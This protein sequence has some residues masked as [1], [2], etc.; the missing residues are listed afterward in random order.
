[1]NAQQAPQAPNENSKRR[2]ILT[3]I[4]VG[5]VFVA[6]TGGLIWAIN[7]IGAEQI[8][9]TIADAGIFG[10]VVYMAITALTFVFAPLTSGPI[11]VGAGILFE[12]FWGVVYTVLG[13]T[14]GGSI[15]FLIARRY[16]RSVVRQLV[17]DDGLTRVETFVAQI[18]DWRTL[19]YAR[20]ILFA[21]FDFISYAAGFSRVRFRTYVIISLTAGAIPAS[22]AVLMGS[23]WT[24]EGNLLLIYGGLLVA[25]VIP[26]LL[27][28]PIRRWLKLDQPQRDDPAL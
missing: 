25:C 23:M 20:I 21:L 22:I 13:E 17:G 18:V 27:N 19:L 24:E 28:K 5:V 10:P 3:L 15:S 4:G 11:Q 1:M 2:S 6:V 26:L 12:P 14:I 16:G 7:S 9:T 8:R